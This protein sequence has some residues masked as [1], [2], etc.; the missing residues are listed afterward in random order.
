MGNATFV[1]RTPEKEQEPK[2]S[3][4]TELLTYLAVH[5]ASDQLQEAVQARDNAP[6]F[7]LVLQLIKD[8]DK[9]ER[10]VAKFMNDFVEETYA[11]EG[12]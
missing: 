10:L 1:G 3:P 9:L 7:E 12:L 11:G 5:H 6:I 4:R 2:L 8:G